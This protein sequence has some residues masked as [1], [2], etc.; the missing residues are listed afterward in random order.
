M[1]GEVAQLGLEGVARGVG[2]L[3]LAGVVL[4]VGGLVADAA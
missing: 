4:E 2:C 3:E 1:E